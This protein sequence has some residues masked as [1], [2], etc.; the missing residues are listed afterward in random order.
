MDFTSLIMSILM[1]AILMVIGSFKTFFEKPNGTQDAS[2]SNPFPYENASPAAF[3]PRRIVYKDKGQTTIE[4]RVFDAI[5]NILR[6]ETKTSDGDPISTYTYEYEGDHLARIK[7]DGVLVKE[8]EIV[9]A[10]EKGMPINV[11]ETCYEESDVMFAG[12]HATIEYKWDGE[13][14]LKSI[15]KRSYLPEM[16][17]GSDVMVDAGPFVSLD[18]RFENGRVVE[19]TVTFSEA[20][21]L[22]IQTHDIHHTFEYEH[23]ATGKIIGCTRTD[24]AGNKTHMKLGYNEKGKLAHIESQGAV[25]SYGYD[26]N[27]A[28]LAHDDEENATIDY[29]LAYSEASPR[30]VVSY[31][32]F[33]GAFVPGDPDF[34][35]DFF[36]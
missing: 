4:N 30:A 18:V 19:K 12:G 1:F 33:S 35:M 31:Y 17:F 20:N 8:F 13:L 28:L 27:G 29:T 7:R 24:E 22:G 16:A 14:C 34:A 23:H 25:R 2:P 15:S 5:G 6:K 10:D 11:K 26:E 21:P 36:S 3:L 9:E 32:A